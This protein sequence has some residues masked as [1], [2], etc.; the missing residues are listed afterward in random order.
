MYGYNPQASLDRINN[1]IAELERLKQQIPQQ[2]MQQPTN[3]TQNFQLA[4]NNHTSMRFA[5][6]IE[7]VEKEL[8]I[9]DTPFFSK[10]MGVLWVKNASGGVKS[11]ELR[12]IIKKDEKDLKIELLEAQIEELRRVNYARTDNTNVD[13]PVESEKPTNVSNGRTSKTKPK[14]PNGDV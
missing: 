2:Q 6:S 9:T 12:E 1:Q 11:Y 7:E 10:D 13:E 14:Q 8:V 3:L 5:N 4:P